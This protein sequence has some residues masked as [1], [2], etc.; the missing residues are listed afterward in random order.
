[1]RK[2]D[3]KLVSSTRGILMFYVNECGKH[4]T[5]EY[6]GSNTVRRQPYYVSIDIDAAPAAAAIIEYAPT[7]TFAHLYSQM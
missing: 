4:V 6:A 7:V 2:Y 1:M 3:G 5:D